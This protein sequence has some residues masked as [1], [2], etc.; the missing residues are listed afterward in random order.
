LH[1]VGWNLSLI[2]GPPPWSPPEA[3]RQPPVHVDAV[4]RID[5]V[6]SSPIHSTMAA[7]LTIPPLVV[8]AVVVNFIF[9]SLAFLIVGLRLCTR[10]FMVKNLGADDIFIAISMV[11]SVRDPSCDLMSS[12]DDRRQNLGKKQHGAD[13][14]RPSMSWSFGSMLMLITALHNK[15]N[16][17]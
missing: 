5:S 9:T 8:P 7:T 6:T 17:C 10:A 11:S 2:T 3:P 1:R 13:R 15:R 14:S 12:V 16:R 4:A